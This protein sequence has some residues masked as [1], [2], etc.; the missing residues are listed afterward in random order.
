MPA[1][2]I[3]AAVPWWSEAGA[4]PLGV[5]GS[6]AT[7]APDMEAQV[8]AWLPRLPT[9][10]D[11]LRL[12]VALSN[13]ARALVRVHGEAALEL[14]Q[15]MLELSLRRVHGE[16]PAT[17]VAAG[18]IVDRRGHRQAAVE[19]TRRALE[20]DPNREAALVNMSRYLVGHSESRDRALELALRATRLRP[21]SVRAWRNLA[22]IH[23]KRGENELAQEALE[24]VGPSAVSPSP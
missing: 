13:R 3:F 4:L 16:H 2:N 18:A 19:L 9:P 24:H 14:V 20:L 11:R 21:W 12:A 23:Q 22:W 15:G 17:L 1:S 10:A 7:V 8:D 5:R 6:G